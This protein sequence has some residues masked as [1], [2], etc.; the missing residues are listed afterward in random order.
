MLFRSNNKKAVSEFKTHPVRNLSVSDGGKL[1]YTQH[2]GLF[3]QVPGQAPEGVNVTFQTDTHASDYLTTTLNNIS[4][5]AV[6]P[7]GKEIAIVA[8]GEIF[9]TSRDFRT[10][11][12]VTNT[13]ERERSVSFHPDG[14]TLLYAGERNQ[15]WNLYE[16]SLADEKEKYFFTATQLT[17]KEIYS[18]E[19][20]S[21]QPAY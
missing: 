20:D 3:T 14:R 18:A 17:E 1:A 4:E 21:F 2:G 13:S 12:R 6:S 19:R 9:V 7:N 5:F 15:K 11:R 10:T 8:R 16:T